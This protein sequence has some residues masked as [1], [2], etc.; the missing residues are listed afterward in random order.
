MHLLAQLALNR[1]DDLPNLLQRLGSDRGDFFRLQTL[2][3]VKFER[4]ALRPRPV[5]H[6]VLELFKQVLLRQGLI[7]RTA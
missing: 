1:S 6:V 5:L 4:L 2:D 7:G 3:E